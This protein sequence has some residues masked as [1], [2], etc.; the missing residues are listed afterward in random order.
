VADLSCSSG[1][2]C[3]EKQFHEEDEVVLLQLGSEVRHRS[4]GSAKFLPNAYEAVTELAATY[5]DNNF[6]CKGNATDL[7]K[8]GSNGLFF[9]CF[10]GKCV[11]YG[12]RCDGA[13]DCD[14]GTDEFACGHSRRPALIGDLELSFENMTD[15]TAYLRTVSS[16]KLAQVRLLKHKLQAVNSSLGTDYNALDAILRPTSDLQRQ[17]QDMK[18]QQAKIDKEIDVANNK[19]KS[20]HEKVLRES[21]NNTELLATATSINASFQDIQD[22]I[23]T[24]IIQSNALHGELNK[25]DG[26]AH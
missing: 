8:G 11:Y 5:G 6:E 7:P 19:S 2:S 23:N 22:Q 26:A 15:Y 4:Q 1:D 9:R 12:L 25:T 13:H 14:D 18:A 16:Q 24:L 10:S 3:P 20:F 21:S 17:A